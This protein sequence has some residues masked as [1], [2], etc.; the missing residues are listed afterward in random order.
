MS[1]VSKYKHKVK[2]FEAL[3]NVLDRKGIKYKENC[4]TSLYGS[5]KVKAEV[6]FK[7]PGWRYEVAVTSE[8]EIL[9]DHYGSSSGTIGLLGET[10]KEYNQEVVMQEVNCMG[11][12]WWE[13]EMEKATKLVLE[14]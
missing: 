6:A 3:K 12:H 7:L 9:F 10:V 1:H 5:N 11:V 8:G 4:M 14:F 13:E 2:D